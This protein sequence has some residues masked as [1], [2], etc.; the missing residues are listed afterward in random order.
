MAYSIV[1]GGMGLRLTSFQERPREYRGESV[2]SFDNSLMSGRDRPARTWDG[3]TDSYSPAEENSLR[4][5]VEAGNVVCSG[6]GLHSETLLCEVTIESTPRGPNVQGALRD[7]ST[8]NV[9][10][11]LVLR[12]VSP[13]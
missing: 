5:I 13:A 11:S 4:S 3:V 1:V 6:I 10:M 9:T 8:V 2:R 12:E 7:Y